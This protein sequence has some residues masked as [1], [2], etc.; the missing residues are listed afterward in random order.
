MKKLA[1]GLVAV[2]GLTSALTGCGNP[3]SEKDQTETKQVAQQE[4]VKATDQKTVKLGDHVDFLGLIVTFEKATYLEN[5]KGVK[6][7]VMKIDMKV[8]N[9][10]AASRGFTTID[11]EIKD[12]KGKKLAIYPGEN[13]G[14]KIKPG[15]SISGSGY[16]T[17]NGNAP[18]TITYKDQDSDKKASWKVEVK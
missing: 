8:E 1:I 3:S 5:D 11:M 15:K 17:V 14:E 16:F 12:S 7:S 10:S 18:Y 4:T 2:I 13:L 6:N 9:K